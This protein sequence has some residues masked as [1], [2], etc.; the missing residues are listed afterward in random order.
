MAALTLHIRALREARGWTQG[1]LAERAGVTRATVN[2]IENG[3]PSSIDLDVLEKLAG[4]LGV[5]PGLLIVQNVGAARGA[6][7]RSR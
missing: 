3:K 4:A 2:R 7:K 6:A 1:D 5:A